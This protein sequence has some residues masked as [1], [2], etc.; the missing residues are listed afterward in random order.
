MGETRVDAAYT[1]VGHRFIVATGGQDLVTVERY[2]TQQTKAGQ[3]EKMVSLQEERWA[4]S[5]CALGSSVV[6]V[7]LSGTN[8]GDIF[9]GSIEWLDTRENEARW[10]F[11][12]Q[13]PDF[14]PRIIP[15]TV[16]LNDSHFL[17]MG[18]Y[19]ATF[20][21]DL[22]IYDSRNESLYSAAILDTYCYLK[23]MFFLI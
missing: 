12:H 9:L 2:D 22:L 19:N 15:I 8:R 4:H 17:I 10:H 23:A 16:A 1:V 18:G 11:M 14:R 20:R 21:G 7:F 13:R 3:W 6:Y 5:S